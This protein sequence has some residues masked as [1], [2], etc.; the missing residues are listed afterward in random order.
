[1]DEKNTSGA[2]LEL[3][4]DL[5]LN[6]LCD[7]N[8]PSVS[9]LFFDICDNKFN[10][11]NFYNTFLVLN[12]INLL[13]INSSMSSALSLLLKECKI[14]I[15]RNTSLNLPLVKDNFNELEEYNLKNLENEIF[16]NVN[17]VEIKK[18]Y[19]PYN[20]EY[21]LPEYGKTAII[22]VVGNIITAPNKEYKQKVEIDH[23][24]RV[25]RLIG[26][27]EIIDKI[28]NNSSIN[29]DDIY[30]TLLTQVLETSEDKEKKDEV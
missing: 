14:K 27:P 15:T 28:V 26:E 10:L 2:L 1:M 13:E 25:L 30:K 24:G 20:C 12:I 19:I 7:N 16:S 17:G 21:E 5:V 29:Y 22:I 9:K 11:N 6:N 8:Y 3:Y 23:K 18:R 4:E